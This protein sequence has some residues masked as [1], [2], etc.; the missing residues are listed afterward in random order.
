MAFFDTSEIADIVA[1]L[2]RYQR[3]G[4]GWDEWRIKNWPEDFVARWEKALD[5]GRHNGYIGPHVSNGAIK[6][7]RVRVLTSDNYCIMCPISLTDCHGTTTRNRF[8]QHVFSPCGKY[9]ID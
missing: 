5:M 6:W 1:A 7:W 2:A 9:K 8:G 4:S 3:S